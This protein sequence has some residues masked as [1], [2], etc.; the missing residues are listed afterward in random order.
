MKRRRSRWVD[1]WGWIKGRARFSYSPQF[2]KATGANSLFHTFDEPSPL[3]TAAPTRSRIAY[4]QGSPNQ[5]FSTGF[6]VKSY[7]T[8]KLIIPF[9]RVFFEDWSG[10]SALCRITEAVFRKFSGLFHFSKLCRFAGSVVSRTVF[11]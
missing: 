1:R 9:T 11:L 5:P 2:R 6:P 4:F 3:P 8:H 10:I 7:G